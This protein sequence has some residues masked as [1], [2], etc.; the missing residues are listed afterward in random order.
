LATRDLDPGGKADFAIA[1]DADDDVKV[2][3]V[4]GDGHLDRL[5]SLSAM[6]VA[7]HGGAQTPMLPGKGHHQSPACAVD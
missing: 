2:F 4:D 7:V 5:A 1:N 3:L 6:A